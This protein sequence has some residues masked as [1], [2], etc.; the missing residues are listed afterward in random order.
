M[1]LRRG[2]I[3]AVEFDDHCEHVGRK[4]DGV[5]R[6]VACGA[7]VSSNRREIVLSWWTLPD[8]T[9]TIRDANEGRITIVRKAIRRMRILPEKWETTKSQ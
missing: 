1:R 8:E 3:V 4:S 9:Q 7:I 2:M 5:I 6:I